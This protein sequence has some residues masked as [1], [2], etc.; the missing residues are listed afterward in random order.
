[1]SLRDVPVHIIE[2]QLRLKDFNFSFEYYH[3]HIKAHFAEILR[4]FK[5]DLV[6]LVHAQNLS[7][8]IIEACHEHSVPVVF[9]PLIFGSFARLCNLNDLMGLS[10]E[11]RGHLV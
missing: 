6:Q 10:V 2:E 8:S 5:P 7:T 9:T 1:M 11:A 3:P 4:E